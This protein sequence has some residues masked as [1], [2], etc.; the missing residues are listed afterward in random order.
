MNCDLEI[1]S[2]LIKCCV[3]SVRNNPVW[4]VSIPIRQAYEQVTYISGFV[5]PRSAAAFSR[6]AR[7]AMMIDSVPPAVVTPAP[8]SGALKADSICF[9]S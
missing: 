5:T 1:L 9:S 6:A 2:R 3:C 8:S 7:H 4:S